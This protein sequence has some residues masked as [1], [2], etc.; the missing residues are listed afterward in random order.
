MQFADAGFS[1]FKATSRPATHIGVL[2]MSIWLRVRSFICC[3]VLLV[4]SWTPAAPSSDAGTN[5]ADN[6]QAS[7]AY[8]LAIARKSGVFSFAAHDHAVLARESTLNASVRDDL[9]RSS[10]VITIPVA[11]LVIDSTQARQLAGLGAGP[12]PSDVPKIQA[13]MLGPEVLDSSHYPAIQFS[14]TSVEVRGDGI[15]R[16]VGNLSLHGQQRTVDFPVRYQKDKTGGL[17]VEGSFKIRQTDF[18]IRPQTIALGGVKVKDE[19]EIRFRSWV[20]PTSGMQS[21]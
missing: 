3:L 2:A 4:P 6:T 14:S 11:S 21:P 10:V 8:F 19:V 1:G 18:G 20:M 15:L 17:T 5:P 16:L 7:G 13:T 12:S 9:A